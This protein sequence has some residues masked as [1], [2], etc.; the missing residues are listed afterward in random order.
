MSFIAACECNNHAE[1]CTYNETVG[2][3]VCDNCTHNTEG[4]NCDR[5]KVSFYRNPD[6]PHNDSNT[7]L[8][9]FTVLATILC[10]TGTS[11]IISLRY[12]MI[13]ACC[14]WSILLDMNGPLNLN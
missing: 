6:V 11:I 14:D 5:C 10:T 8:G 1:S 7:C 13:Y 12:N 4:D 3:G 9:K 2:Y